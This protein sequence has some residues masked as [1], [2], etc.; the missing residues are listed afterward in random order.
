MAPIDLSKARPDSAPPDPVLAVTARSHVKKSSQ[1]H[2]SP[3]PRRLS[4]AQSPTRRSRRGRA[5]DI[6]SWGTLKRATFLREADT[7]LISMTLPR[8]A[9]PREACPTW[10]L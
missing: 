3:A 4:I 8:R 10:Y 6:G 9:F 2:T 7:T 1:R 5:R